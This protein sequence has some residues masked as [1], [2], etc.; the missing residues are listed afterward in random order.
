MVFRKGFL[1]QCISL[2]NL[3]FHNENYYSLNNCIVDTQKGSVVAF[4][5][6]SIIPTLNS[7]TDIADYAF[8][9]FR[10]TEIFIPQNIR[11]ISLYA[12]YEAGISECR[13][14]PIM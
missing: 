8:W 10:G 7:V 11:S 3:A 2:R 12:F 5:K 13:S 14:I 9:H 1:H 4:C 6:T